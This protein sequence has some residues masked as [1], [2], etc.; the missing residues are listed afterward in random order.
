MITGSS[1]K[2]CQIQFRKFHRILTL[3]RQSEKNYEGK[4]QRQRKSSICFSNTYQSKSEE[5]ISEEIRNFLKPE[6]SGN[7]LIGWS[8]LKV[9][10][11]KFKDTMRF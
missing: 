10:C 6:K 2:G 5:N 1:I 9:Y 3:T 7:S 8:N 4:Y 11:A